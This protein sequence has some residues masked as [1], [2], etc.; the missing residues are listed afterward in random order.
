MVKLPKIVASIALGIALLLSS[1]AAAETLDDLESIVAPFAT[2]QEFLADDEAVRRY[3]EA[4]KAYLGDSDDFDPVYKEFI[5]Q[6]KKVVENVPGFAE[7]AFRLNPNW[8]EESFVIRGEYSGTGL[9]V[10]RAQGTLDQVLE[11]IAT[12]ARAAGTAIRHN[13]TRIAELVSVLESKYRTLPDAEYEALSSKKKKAYN[14]QM[15]Q[16]A[17]DPAAV[18]LSNYI[19]HLAMDTNE[20]LRDWLYSS[21]A[22]LT[23][24]ALQSLRTVESQKALLEG[25]GIKIPQELLA[26]LRFEPK[27][28]KEI[29]NTYESGLKSMNAFRAIG[30][31]RME[32][33]LLE[34]MLELQAE[35]LNSNQQ[36]EKLTPEEQSKLRDYRTKLSE[37]GKKKLELAKAYESTENPY[38]YYETHKDP[39]RGTIRLKSEAGVELHFIP[40]PRALH[41]M[42]AGRKTREC[43][44]GSECTTLVVKRW[45]R[46]AL[47]GDQSHFTETGDQKMEGM[48]GITPLDRAT[49]EEKT[50]YSVVDLMSRAIKGD[51]IVKLP[52][53]RHVKY[54]FFDRFVDF[55][56]PRLTTRGMVISDGNS[57]SQNIGGSEVVNSS[58]A[59]LE[60]QIIGKPSEFAP[61][62]PM[63]ADIADNF[64]KT[65]Y[66]YGQG[67]LIYDGMRGDGTKVVR[68]VPTD[69][70]RKRSKEEL[71]AHIGFQLVNGNTPS[72]R[73]AVWK[74]AKDSD[75]QLGRIAVYKE[76][77]QDPD[78]DFSQ[79]VFKYAVR[80]EPS[81]EKL[82][83]LKK[84]LAAHPGKPVSPAA[85]DMIARG[86]KSEPGTHLAVVAAEALEHAIASHPTQKGL[87]TDDILKSLN[88]NL[89]VAGGRWSDKSSSS[90]AAAK[91]LKTAIATHPADKRLVTTQLIRSLAFALK[92][93]ARADGSGEIS[94]A[95]LA[96]VQAHPKNRSVLGPTVREALSSAIGKAH[97]YPSAFAIFRTLAKAITDNPDSKVWQDGKM[98]S[99]MMEG[100]L[101]SGYQ[102]NSPGDGQKEKQALEVIEE[103]LKENPRA[104]V[105]VFEKLL[106]MAPR[107]ASFG[108][109][110]IADSFR[111]VWMSRPNDPH[112][113]QFIVDR[114]ANRDSIKFASLVL[115]KAI[116]A[117]PTEKEFVTDDLIK[118]MKPA[119][120][121]ADKARYVEYPLIAAL[122][123]HPRNKTLLAL[124]TDLLV[125][126]TNIRA[127]YESNGTPRAVT[128]LHQ[129]ITHNPTELSLVSPEILEGLLQA[130]RYNT[131]YFSSLSAP[132]RA[133]PALLL[134]NDNHLIRHHIEND[135]WL[136]A[137]A[138]RALT[139][140]ENRRDLVTVVR[141]IAKGDSRV[142]YLREKLGEKLL[143]PHTVHSWETKPRPD[144]TDFFRRVR[145]KYL[146]A[147]PGESP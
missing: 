6:L 109:E 61:A 45:A 3:G 81:V 63:A 15:G 40:K 59:Y 96:A 122:K 46:Y 128:I 42:L 94:E 105:R 146:S 86:L 55:F 67:G 57:V 127:R 70:R 144:C 132:L 125:N 30:D 147:P 36:W 91:A 85:L 39:T 22:D 79:L 118:A 111:K 33:Q 32:P 56:Q 123:N 114:F 71:E 101:N 99:A 13:S 140:P 28:L 37:A 51:I 143:E 41:A 78:S 107:L 31:P 84:L 23:Y 66:G 73:D 76:Q 121:E 130:T 141:Q 113:K 25:L 74:W 112:F 65:F 89:R 133:H 97:E 104:G 116:D 43:V 47:D 64:P 110:S 117:M 21:D 38:F 58:P 137:S 4:Y 48:I 5:S 10:R 19:A 75:V 18:E 82:R 115:S 9:E 124:A 100:F 7:K 34:R 2:L 88:R 138:T 139:E 69:E 120:L 80:G 27:E 90:F 136:T 60:N 103:I 50:H 44:G 126:H 145:S 26:R 72:D 142:E 119:F 93:T 135:Q 49:G 129:A 108:Q 16:F 62:D 92:R 1:P 53:G 134:L 12:G 102:S 83:A 17:S 106:E 35:G 8:K 20:D 14:A 95:I 131:Q 87:I 77:L 54:S 24:K 68:L 52:S 29:V 11:E 98:I